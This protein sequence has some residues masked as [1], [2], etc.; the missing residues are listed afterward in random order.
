MLSYRILMVIYLY[1]NTRAII[2]LLRSICIWQFHN[3]IVAIQLEVKSYIEGINY[4]YCIHIHIHAWI[5]ILAECVQRT[6]SIFR[7]VFDFTN[8]LHAKFSE[9]FE[10]QCRFVNVNGTEKELVLFCATQSAI[11]MYIFFAVKF[12]WNYAEWKIFVV[13]KYYIHSR[14]P[15]CCTYFFSRRHKSKIDGIRWLILQS[16][17]LEFFK[18]SI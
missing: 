17:F 13:S 14:V 16:C 12:S 11:K 3:V 4:V 15:T 7:N 6:Y 10:S 5:F 18:S 2:F 1:D 9:K 8:F